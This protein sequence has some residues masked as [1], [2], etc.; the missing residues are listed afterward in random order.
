MLEQWEAEEPEPVVRIRR[1]VE[2]VVTNRVDIQSYG[3]PVGTL[4]TELAKLGHPALG[5]AGGLFT[6]FREWLREQFTRLGHEA[7]NQEWIGKGV[8][9]GVFLLVGGIEPG[10]GGAILAHATS[11]EELESRVAADPFVAEGVVS[12]EIVEITPRLADDRLKFLLA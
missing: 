12:A 9:D 8:D 10:L 2:I 5:D 6:L 7:E 3:C 11:R 4:T 1:F